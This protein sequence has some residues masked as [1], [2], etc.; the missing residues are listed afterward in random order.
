MDNQAT[1][2]QVQSE[3]SSTKAKHDDIKL[4]FTRDCAKKGV[5]VPKYVAS[6]EKI[7]ALLTKALPSPRMKVLREK[8]GPIDI[9]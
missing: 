7:A 3:T 1:I 6:E 2:V 9:E 5:M 4:K 8:I